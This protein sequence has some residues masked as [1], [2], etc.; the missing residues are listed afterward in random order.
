MKIS[1]IFTLGLALVGRSAAAAM[2]NNSTYYNPILPGW[3]SDPSCIH[4]SGT[5]YCVTSTFIA[6]PGL[7]IYASKD[8]VNWKHVSHVWTR[9]SQLPGYSWATKG[10]QEGM[11][12]ATIRFHD[13]VFYVI[14]EY[15]GVGGKNSGV[16][17]KSSDPLSDSSWSDAVTFP[18]PKID[19]DLFW[20]D[21][22]KVY[23]ATQGIILQE[24][25]L[26]TGEMSEAV[27]LWNGT[28]GV[29]PEGPHIYKRDG[30]YYLMI[31]EGGTAED[32]AITIARSKNIKG[33]YE[34]YANN[35]ILSNRG[36]QEYFQTV[37]HGD[38]FQDGEGNWWGTSLATRSGPAYRS[39]PMGRETV[40]FPVTWNT[41]EWPILQPVRGKMSGWPLPP[42]NR[43]IPGSG[44]GPFVSDPDV[45]DFHE[46]S[47][48]PRNLI[49]WRVPRDGAFTIAADGNNNNKKGLQVTLG[50]NSLSGLP[51]GPEPAAKAVS[52]LGRRQT[53]SLFTFSVDL[54]FAPQAA[55]Q[56]AGVVAFL[57]QAA[58]IQL[59]VVLLDDDDSQ[60][61]LSFRFNAS[62]KI[63]TT[64]VPAEWGVGSGEAIRLEIRMVKPTEYV[65]SAMLASSSSSS[66][67]VELGTASA[68]LLSG[69]SGSFV[70][71]L[72]G[73]YATCN[74]AGK[75]LD[76]PEGTPN[77]YFN[78]WRYTGNAQYI[79][80][81]EAVPTGKGACKVRKTL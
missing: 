50:R 76:C 41:G 60:Q 36:T 54:D 52:F 3:H 24:M 23:V 61:Q 16:L 25:N 65:F 46:P 74:G 55:G 35:P 51:G 21:D 22:G 69:G 57:T 13:D 73:V 8:L 42:A 15:L 71:T 56:E 78:R 9:E 1:A 11:Y 53:H 33:P 14:C 68:E 80:E 81:T 12:A 67:K 47:T 40:L 70:G 7:P 63:T 20:D 32:H 34:P 26:D 2:E 64:D 27:S 6:F 48:I 58:T 29:W 59:G 31:A 19:P 5:F 62:G 77:A 17:F 4:V 39:Y 28:G 10:Q 37:G 30:Y 79:S 49:H 72:I 75:G 43:D 38:L 18:A 44:D 45:Y 66:S